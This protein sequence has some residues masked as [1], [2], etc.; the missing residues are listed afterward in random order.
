MLNKIFFKF[1]LRKYDEFRNKIVITLRC[2]WIGRIKSEMCY[3][4]CFEKFPNVDIWI[5]PEKSFV[6]NFAIKIKAGKLFDKIRCVQRNVCFEFQSFKFASK[7]MNIFWSCCYFFHG[8]VQKKIA[9]SQPMKRSTIICLKRCA[10][11][12]YNNF[13][14]FIT[15]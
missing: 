9:N 7:L 4:W 12:D 1:L 14:L 5:I 8:L 6:F 11:N 10:S 3:R 15:S 2:L 13:L